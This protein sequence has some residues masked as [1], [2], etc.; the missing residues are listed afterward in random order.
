MMELVTKTF[1]EDLEKAGFE[2][3]D[4]VGLVRRCADESS[5]LANKGGIM[6]QVEYLVY[7][8]YGVDLTEMISYRRKL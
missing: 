4:L 6:R 3:E 2:S 1:L 7:H 8:E 5:A